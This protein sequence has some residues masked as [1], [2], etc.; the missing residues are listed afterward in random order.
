MA[1]SEWEEYQ[2]L[3][4]LISNR[5]ESIFKAHAIP[6]ERL[7]KYTQDQIKDAMKEAFTSG[8]AHGISEAYYTM[9]EESNPD[10]K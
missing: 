4:Q 10:S 5:V 9:H 7:D 8:R 3:Q 2:E 1:K 6:F